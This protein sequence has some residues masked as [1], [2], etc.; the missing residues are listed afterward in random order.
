MFFTSGGKKGNEGEKA[1]LS[2]FFPFL[3][4]ICSEIRLNGEAPMN[5][6]P[7][8]SVSARKAAPAKA[9]TRSRLHHAAVPEERMIRRAGPQRPRR[10]V[11][12]SGS[13]VRNVLHDN[14]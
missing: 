4:C 13:P 7:R 10:P 9:A 11:P 5:P 6:R 8:S 2:P 1:P 14:R 12:G 3:P